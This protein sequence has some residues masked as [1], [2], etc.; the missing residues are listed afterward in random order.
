M[1]T[2]ESVEE[3]EIESGPVRV[4]RLTF[5]ASLGFWPIFLF[6]TVSML[7]PPGTTVAAVTERNI[8]VYS[9]WFYPL[10]VGLGWFLS[11]RAMRIGRSDTIC[12]MPWLIPAAVCCYWLGYLLF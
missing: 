2:T 5:L 10:A 1:K 3:V 6:A 4:A 8:L 7:A 12:L 11:K 9:V